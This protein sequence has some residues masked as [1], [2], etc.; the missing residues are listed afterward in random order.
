MKIFLDTANVKEV[1]R[2]VQWGVIDGVTTN[3]SLIAREGRDFHQVIREMADHLDGPVNAE[4]VSTEAD[5]MVDEA[6]TLSRLADNVVVKIPMI[7]E[8]LKA[9]HRLAEEGIAT[10]VT[11]I[12]SVNQALLAARAGAAYVSPFV[13]RLDDIGHDGMNVVREAAAIFKRYDLSTETLAASIRHPRHVLEA[14]QAGADVATM[15]FSTLEKMLTH[16]LTDTGLERF[17]ADW[18]SARSESI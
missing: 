6:H 9:V 15:P 10:N 7:A 17:L 11:L 2:G 1:K 18:K 3:P 16:P 8:G 12:F 14:A 13:G 5:G 4:V